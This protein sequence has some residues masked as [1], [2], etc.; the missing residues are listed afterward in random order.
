MFLNSS[1]TFYFKIFI[2]T[3]A[4]IGALMYVAPLNK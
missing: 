4:V 2:L 3:K 1:L